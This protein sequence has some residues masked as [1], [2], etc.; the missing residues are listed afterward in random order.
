MVFNQ[1]GRTEALDFLDSIH[2]TSSS[3]PFTHVIFTTNNSLRAADAQSSRRELLNHQFDPATL[4][5]MTVQRGF[6]Q[7]WAAVDAGGAEVLLAPSVE[8]TIELIR[9]PSLAG[10]LTSS[11]EA[12]VF[13]TGSLHLVGAFL[14]MLESVDAL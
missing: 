11:Q 1:Q 12:Q 5:S 3:S 9:G 4:Q 2:A 10:G 13:V 6:A 8:E 7:R 14:G